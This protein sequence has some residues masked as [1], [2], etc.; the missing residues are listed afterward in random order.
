MIFSCGRN[1]KF[2]IIFKKFTP[3]TLSALSDTFAQRINKQKAE[4][5]KI[6]AKTILYSYLDGLL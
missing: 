4:K 2:I 1:L 5:L 3:V 6:A